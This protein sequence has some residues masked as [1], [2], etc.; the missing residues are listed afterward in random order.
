MAPAASQL[1]LDRVIDEKLRALGRVGQGDVKRLGCDNCA[2]KFNSSGELARH[3]KS[4]HPDADQAGG[5]DRKRR[6]GPRKRY[7][8]DDDGEDF[9]EPAEEEHEE[10][11]DDEE[12]KKASEDESFR[13]ED[14][15]EFLRATKKRVRGGSRFG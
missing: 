6:S 7:N 1:E 2:L 3:R 12:Q 14:E 11:A 15:E 9:E 8:E 13:S 5:M 4:A 10:E